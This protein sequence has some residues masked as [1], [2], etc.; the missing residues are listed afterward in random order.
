LQTFKT[1]LMH[2][3]MEAKRVEVAIVTFGPVKTALDFTGAEQYQPSALKAGGDTPMGAA[4][5]Q[6]IEMLKERKETYKRNGI[7]YFRPWVFLITDGAPT[8]SWQ[9][10]AE[11][12]KAGEAAK[13]FQFYAV[14]VEKADMRILAQIAVREPLRL[15]GL[16]FSR[17]FSWLSSSLSSVSH[18][19][20]GELVPLKNPTGPNG[21][22][23]AG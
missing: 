11:L 21:W 19:S 4:I 10:A 14:G 18:S 2:D 17:L 23:T 5:V 20:P 15:Q 22:A 16:M 8:D 7:S 6:G 3:E 9:Q 13:A 1:E 12:V